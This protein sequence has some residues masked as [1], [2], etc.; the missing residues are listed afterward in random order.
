MVVKVVKL[1]EKL[2]TLSV[3]TF[4]NSQ[5]SVCAGICVFINLELPRVWTQQGILIARGWHAG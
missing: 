1:T 5:G 4:Q 3:I 2:W